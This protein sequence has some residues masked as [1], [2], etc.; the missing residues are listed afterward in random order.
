M[1]WKLT[2]KL[3]NAIRA[4]PGEKSKGKKEILLEYEFELDDWIFL[5]V[6]FSLNFVDIIEKKTVNVFFF[7]FLL[8]KIKRIIAL[9]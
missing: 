1:V 2:G 9:V 8:V 4:F 3:L 5:T 6:S 7:F